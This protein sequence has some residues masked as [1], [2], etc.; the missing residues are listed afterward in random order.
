MSGSG[1]VPGTWASV[2]IQTSSTGIPLDKKNTDTRALFSGLRDGDVSCRASRR[3]LIRN[4]FHV[5]FFGFAF[6]QHG[7][8]HATCVS[9]NGWVNAKSGERGRFVDCT[10]RS[11]SSVLGPEGKERID[12]QVPPILLT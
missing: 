8:A 9:I 4:R 5:F 7:T 3:K 11:S 12:T 10:L 6:V 2:W 1:L